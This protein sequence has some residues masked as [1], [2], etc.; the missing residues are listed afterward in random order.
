MTCTDAGTFSSRSARFSAV[1]T[2][3]CRTSSDLLVLAAGGPCGFAVLCA[4]V[5]I[6]RP[7][8][9]SANAP[10]CSIGMVLFT[11]PPM[12]SERL[13][14]RALCLY[15]QPAYGWDTGLKIRLSR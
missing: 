1:T 11:H 8:I 3:S 10:T 9:T 4:Q 6:G 15:V 14:A 13:E 12:H 5:N 2:T 7:N